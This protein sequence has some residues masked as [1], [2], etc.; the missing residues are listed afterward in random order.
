V[1]DQLVG[2]T[3]V[4]FARVLIVGGGASGLA[5]AL[6]CARLG[7]AVRI[8]EK[9]VSRT[10]V[11]K[12]TGVAQ[13]VWHQLADF[14]ITEKVISEA[15]PMRRFV[16][17]DDASLVADI[18]VPN[19]NGEPPAHLY[20]QA[21]LEQAMEDALASYGVKVE[22]GRTFIGV[23]ENAHGIKANV[24]NGQ[25]TEVIEA[26][27]LVAADGS[28]SAV[29]SFLNVPFVGCDYPEEWSVAEIETREWPQDTQ[30]QLFLQADGVGLFL[31]QP[32]RGVI[33][34]I[35]NAKGVALRLS[36]MFR[37]AKLVYE[38]EFRVSLRRVPSPRMGRVWFI[39]DAAH[40][41]SPVGGQGLNL[42]VWDG[43]T[44]GRAL[45]QNQTEVEEA[46][47]N[48]AR[49][50]L[51]FT[52]FDYLMLSTK[53]RS[54]QYLRNSYWKFAARFPRSA[55]WFFRLISGTW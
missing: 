24:S 21:M 13:G 26:D 3:V 23:V 44:L 48:R 20:P 27:W 55:A 51:R 18:R 47:R 7:V 34:G 8:V 49:S 5:C 28:R 45:A 39:G 32:R 9:R 46:L 4:H 12:A 37:D 40:V 53:W 42:A 35:L 2:V 15:I 6:S 14:G 25:E 11:Q 29:R 36:H 50:V 38:R 54:V 52:H 30:A 16:F 41:Q 17:H 19:V 31:S 22:Y 10:S 1:L 43:V 33:Q